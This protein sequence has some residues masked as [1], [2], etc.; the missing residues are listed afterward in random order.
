VRERST[1]DAL[2]GGEWY[3]TDL[4]VHDTYERWLSAAQP[5][6][7]DQVRDRVAQILAEHKPLPLEDEVRRELERIEARALQS[8][9]LVG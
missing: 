5:R 8:H 9:G 6:L 7:L 1:R 4:G 2:H 3:L